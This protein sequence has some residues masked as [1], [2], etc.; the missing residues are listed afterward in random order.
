MGDGTITEVKI[1][2]ATE[3]HVVTLA[4]NTVRYHAFTHQY[5][6]T[7]E[8][9]V[10]IKGYFKQMFPEP[11][12]SIDSGRQGFGEGYF[13]YLLPEP[14]GQYIT[15][16][17]S[18]NFRIKS[19]KLK[20]GAGLQSIGLI[21]GT[22][23]PRDLF[24]AHSRQNIENPLL[25]QRGECHPFYKNHSVTVAGFDFPY[26]RIT[27]WTST[28][29][30]LRAS[31]L[32]VDSTTPLNATTFQKGLWMQKLQPNF[33]PVPR[34]YQSDPSDKL[35]FMA[36]SLTQTSNYPW[37]WRSGSNTKIQGLHIGVSNA[38]Y[39]LVGDAYATQ[40][41]KTWRYLTNRDDY[42]WRDFNNFNAKWY[43]TSSYVNEPLTHA[44]LVS[45][46]DLGG[47]VYRSLN[48][49]SHES[50]IKIN[51]FSVDENPLFDENA[52]ANGY[53]EQTLLGNR[54]DFERFYVPGVP[55]RIIN[56]QF[57]YESSGY[58]HS[59]PVNYKGGIWEINI[60][61]KKSPTTSMLRRDG[62]SS[63]LAK[64]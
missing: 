31:Y 63:P 61:W 38:Y 52:N 47:G 18:S 2:N 36:L 46:P 41:R 32:E 3:S 64:I 62:S 55:G 34:Y 28:I 35:S 25:L 6:T 27:S 56:P 37:S 17:L 45:I 53:N 23:L 54:N 49:N 12:P 7:G 33:D 11:N 60:P 48:D 14:I 30:T 16:W 58:V 50:K 26:E 44:S 15:K 43:E 13:K 4:A 20:G 8:K 29:P 40:N 22:F 21:H 10:K 57:G 42:A 51:A 39:P 19:T 5:S 24:N 9:V 1:A 59:G